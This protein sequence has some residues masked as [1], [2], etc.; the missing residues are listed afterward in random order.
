M[1]ILHI[2]RSDIKGGAQQF[3]FDLV[4]NNPDCKLL[5][6]KKFTVNEERVFLFKRL[7]FDGFVEFLNSFPGKFG[8]TRTIKMFLGAQDEWN[9]T[10]VRL[11]NMDIFKEADIIHLHNIHGG[12]F[13]IKSLAW[14]A[15]QKPII[16]TL[17]DMWALTGGEIHT[18]EHMGYKIGDAKTPYLNKYPLN[19]PLLDRR[20]SFLNLKKRLYQEIGNSIT[21]VPVCGWLEKALK[22]S[23]VY[24]NK[25]N[26]NTIYN[27]IDISI[28]K[29]ENN[30]TWKLPRILIINTGIYL[31]GAHIFEASLDL[32]KDKF[33]IYALGKNMA[34]NNYQVKHF[35]FIQDR[36][37]L[38]DMFNQV[39]IL[40]F[41]SLADT[42]PLT[43]LEAMSCGVCIIASDVG[44]IPE[45]IPDES[46]GFIFKSENKEGLASAISH[47][48]NDLN[49]V[50]GMGKKGA[51]L[52]AEKFSFNKM[53]SKYNNL[54]RSVIDEKPSNEF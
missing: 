15:K 43:I 8:I 34:V 45:M 6:S 14:I 16:W 4:I 44:G 25:I 24:N 46:Y 3:A 11:S 20:T 33:E 48:V 32:L 39:D 26:I 41:P 2:G 53:L 13:D 54:Y 9:S 49:K 29:N 22:E 27:G 52:V 38:A 31:K 17:H 18:F 5:V 30:R 10:K 51:Y 36:K 35:D 19:K 47:A 7:K 42:F 1:K 50:R 12:Y 21:F 23:Y 28:F 37:L 40:V